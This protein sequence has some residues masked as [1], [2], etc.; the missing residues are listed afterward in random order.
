MSAKRTIRDYFCE[1]IWVTTS[2]H[3]STD[4]PYENYNDACTWF[5]GIDSLKEDDKLKIGRDNARK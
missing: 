1:N 4:C 5:D 3:F 2:G